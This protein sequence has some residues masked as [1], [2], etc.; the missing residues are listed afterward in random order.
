MISSIGSS[1]DFAETPIKGEIYYPE[2][3][4]N[5]PTLIIVHG[6]HG[7]ET[8]SY[9]GYEYLGRYLASNGY[10]VVSVDENICNDLNVYNDARAIIFLENI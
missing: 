2:G 7:A 10:V 8:P 1:Y 5:C 9:L 3:G 6:A 4:S